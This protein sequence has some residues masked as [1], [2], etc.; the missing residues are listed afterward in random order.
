ASRSSQ[1]AVREQRS[2][3]FCGEPARRDTRAR[4]FPASLATI[5][6]TLNQFTVAGLL[7]EAVVENGRSYFDTNVTSIITSTT[8]GTVT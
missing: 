3:L 4:D 8:N 5:Y 2:P 1:Y 7:R 6:N